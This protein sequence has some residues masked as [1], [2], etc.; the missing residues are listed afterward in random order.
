MKGVMVMTDLIEKIVGEY[1]DNRIDRRVDEQ[2]DKKFK[3]IKGSG[4]LMS[5]NT[6]L[7]PTEISRIYEKTPHTIFQWIK[8]FK[9][10]PSETSSTKK[11]YTVQQFIDVGK[12]PKE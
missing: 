6:S 7:T 4:N 2:V 1:I 9:I 12:I 3:A 5:H 10:E 8:K 11:Y